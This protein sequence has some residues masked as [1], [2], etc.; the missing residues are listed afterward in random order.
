MKTCPMSESNANNI[1][2]EELLIKENP[3][4]EL[5]EI[6]ASFEF[7]ESF[8]DFL[9]LKIKRGQARK[10]AHFI[11]RNELDKVFPQLLTVFARAKEKSGEK[12][13]AVKIYERLL[14]LSPQNS[15]AS[16]AAAQ[17]S[18]EIGDYDRAEKF[19][20]MISDDDENSSAAYL[21]SG[22]VYRMKN[23][24]DAA[25]ESYSKALDNGVENKADIYYNIAVVYEKS[26]DYSKALEYY[27]KALEENPNFVDAHWNKSLLLLRR[28]EYYE[29]W[30]EF[31]WRK[32]RRDYTSGRY[33][34]SECAKCD[35][36]KILLYA[37]QGFGDAIQFL[38]FVKNVNSE[39][40]AIVVR[41]E[42][43]RLFDAT[44]LFDEV[45]S[46]DEQIPV[47]NYDC[48][49]SLLS[50]PY[51][52][53]LGNEVALSKPLFPVDESVFTSK[54]KIAIAWKGN[55][56]HINDAY[57]SITLEKF[58][59]L[60]NDLN[61]EIHSF[62]KGEITGYERQLLAERGIADLSEKINDFL[63]AAKL[64]SEMDFVVSVDTALVH[65][66]GSMFLPTFVLLPK[67]SDWR[68]GESERTDWYDTVRLF[69]QNTLGDWSEPF[70]ELRETLAE[71][72]GRGKITSDKNKSEKVSGE[73]DYFALA[74]KYDEQ[75]ENEK[76]AEVFRS[77]I[78]SGLNTPEM[79]FNYA[80]ALHKAGKTKEAEREYEKLISE[81]TS[82]EVYRAYSILL[83]QKGEKKKA[84]PFAEKACAIFPNSAEINFVCGNIYKSN[85]KFGKAKKCYLKSLQ[86][87]S[88]FREAEINLASI[89]YILGEIENAEK[90]YTRLIKRNSH[91]ADLHYNLALI[92]QEKKRY[93]DALR[94]IDQA[95]SLKYSPYY[96]H[97]K[98]EILFSL[99]RFAE[100]FP[101]FRSRLKL[102]PPV[103]EP[104]LP[105]TLS[106]LENARI[107]IFE[108]QGVGDTI[109]MLRF[110]KKLSEKNE[111][112]FA[113]RESL[114]PLLQ[115]QPYAV[116]VVNIT[117]K[118]ATDDFD[119]VL[120]VFSLFELFH[121]TKGFPFPAEK[122]LFVNPYDFE[123]SGK[124]KIGIA[125]RGN[126]YPPHQRK[127]HFNVE[128]LREIF[129]TPR[130]EFFPLHHDLTKAENDFLNDYENVIYDEK[131]FR[132]FLTLTR[133]INSLDLIVT[134]DTVY[135]HLSGAL[136]K[137]TFTLVH[138]S[139]DWRWG[140][141][142]EKSEWYSSHTILRQP[143]YGD[144]A[145]V[146]AELKKRLE[147]T[148]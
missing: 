18:F 108:E 9:H 29:G 41:P 117:E 20:R 34:L 93:E 7:A 65:L 59:T 45:Y 105:R 80:L 1:D 30:R 56:N 23:E 132:D 36:G 37:E 85:E 58:L 61:A 32:L 4:K 101:A 97:A 146:I 128:L 5:Y 27:E 25:I 124:K 140:A 121:S 83:L 43:K 99:S 116:N 26:F 46:R 44:C 79:K 133:L 103:H 54:K 72:I 125:W 82:E 14:A 86:L 47:G 119:F 38:R 122:Y 127:R 22:N 84:L 115:E 114:L 2:F 55:P 16:L 87:K 98:A 135:A 33:N 112:T 139:P 35:G 130:A 104:K 147:E 12:K 21:I 31:E 52:L 70:S 107:L 60:F 109:Q 39:A 129:S 88:D 17:L 42:L 73:I 143:S 142:G 10:V 48:K 6:F 13:E 110:A 92:F 11:E 69:R 141:G 75:G 118:L 66:A 81:I 137:K 96:E 136:N 138:Y 144:W 111:I 3:S 78:S 8:I 74:Q 102:N 49:I 63:D 89:Y 50:L 76:V 106:E 145:N 123:R 24:F 15:Y 95:L 126:P 91:D 28:G 148:I 67:N 131:Y 53:Q 62:Q 68:W 134:V 57:R 19:A 40:L 71:E 90:I 100:G 51:C 113:A 120:P 64:L 94:E 77:A